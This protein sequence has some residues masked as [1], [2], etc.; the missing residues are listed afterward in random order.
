[1]IGRIVKKNLKSDLRLQK[2]KDSFKIWLAVKTRGIN[3]QRK[4]MS[5][6]KK[7]KRDMHMQLICRTKVLYFWH[8]L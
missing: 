3:L 7:T 5:A 2:L 4:V 1:M 6:G 8:V